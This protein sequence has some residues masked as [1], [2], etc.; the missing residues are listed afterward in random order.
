[1]N[2]AWKKFTN[3][4]EARIQARDRPSRSDPG[5]APIAQ[6]LAYDGAVLVLDPSLIIFPVRSRARELDAVT[7][8]VLDQPIVDELSAVLHSE[9]C[10]RS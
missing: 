9:L 4:R 7:Q 5:K 10:L 1:L 3:S 6:E 2:E 8:A